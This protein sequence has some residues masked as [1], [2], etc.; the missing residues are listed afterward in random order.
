MRFPRSSALSIL[1]L[2]GCAASTDPPAAVRIEPTAPT[3]SLQSTPRGPRLDVSITLT[4]TSSN[5]I[6][7]INC[8]FALERNRYVLTT[9]GGGADWAE[10]WTP[11]CALDN[12]VMP[13]PIKSG[14]SVTVPISA[15][16]SSAPAHV[17]AGDPGVYR[18]RF[19]L[20]AQI[21]GEYHQLPYEISVSKPFTVVAE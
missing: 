2:S 7:W 9:D 8:G 18:V 3:F 13:P 14:Q 6:I 1:V 15:T 5:P 19:Y 12:S 10:V 20:S 4:N 16:P 17:F 21:A 11:V